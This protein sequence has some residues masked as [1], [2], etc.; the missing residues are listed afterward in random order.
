MMSQLRAATMISVMSAMAFVLG[1]G[2]VSAGVLDRIN[3]DKTIRIAY[4]EDGAAVFL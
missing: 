4:R 3:Q 1:G 2:A